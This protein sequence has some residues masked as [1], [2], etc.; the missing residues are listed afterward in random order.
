MSSLDL[1]GDEV[2]QSWRELAAA[3]VAHVKREG[4]ADFNTFRIQHGFPSVPCWLGIYVR[5]AC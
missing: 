3:F 2:P 4:R 5:F 1:F